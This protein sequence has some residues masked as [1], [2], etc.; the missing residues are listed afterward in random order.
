MVNNTCL[1]PSPYG[2]IIFNSSSERNCSSNNIVRHS[3]VPPLCTNTR[4]CS[5]RPSV[6]SPLPT[7]TIMTRQTESENTTSNTSMMT[8]EYSSCFG[9]D[10]G[11]PCDYAV[12]I[13]MSLV[14]IMLC[15][16]L[17]MSSICTCLMKKKNRRKNQQYQG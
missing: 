14:L 11:T 9:G 3:L 13:G 12:I 17:L 16:L 5:N 1:Q 15:I 7:K 10:F 4:S 6:S 2:H 8:T